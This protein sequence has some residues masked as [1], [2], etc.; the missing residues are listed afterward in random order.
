MTTAPF[1][2]AET[3]AGL[4]PASA[5]FLSEERLLTRKEAVELV[6]SEFGLP[7]TLSSFQCGKRKRRPCSNGPAGPKVAKRFGRYSL[8]RPHDVRA[9]AR[10]LIM[11]GRAA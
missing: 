1:V 8:Y 4:S 9:W 2:Y 6:R 11:K 3:N 10:D 7:I 5:N